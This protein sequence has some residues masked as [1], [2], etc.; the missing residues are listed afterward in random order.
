VKAREE[1][2]TTGVPGN[3]SGPSPVKIG[4]GIGLIVAASGTIGLVARRRRNSGRR[5]WA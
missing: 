5:W 2:I 1:I 3:G 4:L